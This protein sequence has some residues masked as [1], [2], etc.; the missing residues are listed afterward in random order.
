MSWGKLSP[1]AGR[2]KY[3]EPEKKQD[4][5]PQNQA[6]KYAN[7]MLKS[8]RALVDGKLTNDYKFVLNNG[9]TYL[10]NFFCKSSD[11]TILNKLKEE[12]NEQKDTGMINWSKHFRH[13]DP[14]FSK[15][16]NEIVDQMAKHFN[17]D[18]L[19]TRLNYYKDG[20][21][22]KPFHHDKHAYGEGNE[23]VRE[24]FTMGASFGASRNLDFRHV[25]SNLS[26]S[27]PQNNGD[28]FAFN[29]DINKAFMHGVPKA[30]SN[31]GERF[32]II[33]WGK[34]KTV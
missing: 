27:F 25:G 29:S 16:F 31:V 24:D 17:V 2:F 1:Y 30:N 26:F 6:S 7:Q 28:I 4:S 11:L 9:C 15:T 8:E 23:K 10:P 3:V 32:S 19:Q 33:A 18:V 14:T 12:L 22:W 34:Q 5:N 21:D 20:N 13:E